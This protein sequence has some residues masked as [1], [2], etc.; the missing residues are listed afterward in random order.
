MKTRPI[1]PIAL[2]LAGLLACGNA[3][4]ITV[5]T[6]DNTDFSAGKTNLWLAI[7]MANTNGAFSN[8]I[9]FNIPGAGPHYLITPPLYVQGGTTLALGGGYPIITNHNLTI[10]ELGSTSEDVA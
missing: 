4:I 9:N 8:T 6:A 5:N 7:K 3:A 2:A 1:A 10:E